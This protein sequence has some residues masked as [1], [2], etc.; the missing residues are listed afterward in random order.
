MAKMDNRA[1]GQIACG[2][3]EST[4]LPDLSRIAT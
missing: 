1:D 2:Q 3:N 4:A